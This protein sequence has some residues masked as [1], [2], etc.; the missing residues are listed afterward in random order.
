MSWHVMAECL[1][2]RVNHVTLGLTTS[3]LQSHNAV[4]PNRLFQNTALFT[5]RQNQSR[6][7]PYHFPVL[8]VG[9]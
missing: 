3:D 7:W 1:G 2:T 4:F 5:L 6:S 9:K 8:I